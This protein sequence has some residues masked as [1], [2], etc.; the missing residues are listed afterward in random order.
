MPRSLVVCRLGSP[1]TRG[2]VPPLIALLGL[3]HKMGWLVVLA[4][5]TILHENSF[6]QGLVP[7]HV[8]FVGSFGMPL[9]IDGF[10][11]GIFRAVLGIM[12]VTPPL[13]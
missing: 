6:L 2:E 13:I 11:L 3:R 1:A 9:A 5:A 10:F 12:W 4:L 7:H 8:Y